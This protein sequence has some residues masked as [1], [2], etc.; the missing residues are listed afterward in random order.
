MNTSMNL[1]SRQAQKC[2]KF[3]NLPCR[4]VQS[5]NLGRQWGQPINLWTPHAGQKSGANG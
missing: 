3:H 5:R 1:T 4:T 2:I